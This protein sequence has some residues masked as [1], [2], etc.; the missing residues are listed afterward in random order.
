MKSRVSPTAYAKTKGAS[1]ND[2]YK[3][4]DDSSAGWW[5]LQAPVYDQNYAANQ[6]T[7]IG[8]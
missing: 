5:W 1:E 3:T 4:E 8:D 6:K 7:R 2:N